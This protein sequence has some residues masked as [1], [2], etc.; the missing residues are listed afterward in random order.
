M[1][2]KTIL[3]IILD[4]FN[5]LMIKITKPRTKVT[6]FEYDLNKNFFNLKDI[7]KWKALKRID[8]IIAESINTYHQPTYKGER[9]YNITSAWDLRTALNNIRYNIAKES[10]FVNSSDEPATVIKH[11]VREIWG[12][13]RT[14]YNK[15]FDNPEYEDLARR[16]SNTRD[17]FFELLFDFSGYLYDLEKYQITNRRIGYTIAD[18][19][20]TEYLGQNLYLINDETLLDEATDAIEIMHELLNKG[21]SLYDKRPLEKLT[22]F[23]LK[24]ARIEYNKND[25]SNITFD[26]VARSNY[27]QDEKLRLN[28]EKKN[29][30]ARKRRS[31]HKA[32]SKKLIKKPAK[33]AVPTKRKSIKKWV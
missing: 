9:L 3:S 32:V 22:L 17:E 23:L 11:F 28:R 29:E 19:G 15:F 10:D 6:S 21:I 5:W 31:Q 33:K 25:Y 4:W 1:K 13:D 18:Y 26:E 14:L 12:Y 2:N 27:L 30:Q 24:K 20:I 16:N 8:N 7:P